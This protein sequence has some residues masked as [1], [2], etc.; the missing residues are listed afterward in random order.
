MLFPSE[1]PGIYKLVATAEPRVFPHHGT[2]G[3]YRV[4][5]PLRASLL[6]DPGAVLVGRSAE[7]SSQGAAVAGWEI[8]RLGGSFQH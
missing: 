2:Q 5:R 6:R 4:P 7:A 3:L 8:S 1:R